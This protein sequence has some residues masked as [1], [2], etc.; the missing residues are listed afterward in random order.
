MRNG[1]TLIELLVVLVLIAMMAALA[2]PRIGSSIA[3]LELKTTAQKVAGM[4]KSARSTAVSEKMP[5]IA[6][7][8]AKKN[9]WRVMPIPES[10]RYDLDGFDQQ[11]PEIEQDENTKILYNYEMPAEIGL[12]ALA[13]DGSIIDKRIVG[14]AFY[15]NGASNGGQLRLYKKGHNEFGYEVA[16]DPLTGIVSVSETEE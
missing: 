3:N 1:F 12:N 10:F 7:F 6:A 5:T 2:V 15:P 13:A 11:W 4:L 14:I 16:V 8:E 9:R